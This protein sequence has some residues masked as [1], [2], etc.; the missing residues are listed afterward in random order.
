M[1]VRSWAR[2]RTRLRHAAT[3][4]LPKRVQVT[5]VRL[6][7]RNSLLL[8][9]RGRGIPVC[10]NVKQWSSKVQG[11]ECMVVTPAWQATRKPPHTIETE[12]DSEYLTRLGTSTRE[13]YVV[14]IQG[15]LLVGRGGVVML[16]D[17]LVASESIYNRPVLAAEPDYFTVKRRPRVAKPGNYYSLLVH[18]ARRGVY[19]HWVHDTLERLY[20]VVEVLP[21]DTRYVVPAGLLPYQLE[22]LRAVGVEDDQ[23]VPF[24]GEEVWELETLHFAPP[25]VSSGANHPP[26]D[27]WLR[28][29]FFDAYGISPGLGSRRIFLSRRNMRRRQ[30]TNEDEVVEFLTPFGFEI[31]VPEA[32]PMKEQVALFADAEVVVSTHG[33]AFTNLLFSP[34]G[35]R[36]VDM[37]EPAMMHL[38]YVFWSMTEQLRQEYW[39]FVAESVPKAGSPNDTYV[40]IDKL[41]ATFER[42]E[43]EPRRRVAP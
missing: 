5:W 43:L 32:L 22:T 29:K 33:S 3:S 26:A 12:I 23:V 24:D 11:P 19:Y 8:A 39:Y 40:P 42:M 25:I 34:P 35:C 41:A 36:V 20:G 31:C 1:Q 21:P 27:A 4:V 37:I 10:D 28:E 13:G 14:P 16:P 38:S 17:G 7:R 9:S 2:A 15:A 6:R 30:V 18:Y